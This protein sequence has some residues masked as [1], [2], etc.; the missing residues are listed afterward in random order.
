MK[1]FKDVSA[2]SVHA[3]E[4]QAHKLHTVSQEWVKKALDKPARV[5]TC[6]CTHPLRK[7]G[8]KVCSKCGLPFMTHWTNKK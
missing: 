6:I 5:E 3:G 4:A 1:S 7:A 8:T 2:I